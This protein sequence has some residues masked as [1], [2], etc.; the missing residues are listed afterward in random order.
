MAFTLP[1][2]NLACHVWHNGATVP[3]VGPPDIPNM[4]CQLA[5]DAHNDHV[6]AFGVTV[7]SLMKV[8]FG[9]RVDVRGPLSATGSDVVEVPANSGRFYVVWYVDDV[10][11]GFGNEY[12]QAYVMLA[13]TPTPMP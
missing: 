9:H 13:Q 10:A 5:W 6:L 1:T 2:L 7:R 3:P 11:R 12:R 4:A 8:R